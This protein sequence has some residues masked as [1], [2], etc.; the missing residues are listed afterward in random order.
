MTRSFSHFHSD[1]SSVC[2]NERVVE[3]LFFGAIP[4]HHNRSYPGYGEFSPSHDPGR[5][6]EAK[7]PLPFSGGVTF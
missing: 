7:H 4:A 3:Q 5:L 2:L 6:C 1:C